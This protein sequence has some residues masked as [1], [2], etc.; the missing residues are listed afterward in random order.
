MNRSTEEE[1]NGISQLQSHKSKKIKALCFVQL[2]KLDK[3]K[4][5]YFFW[6]KALEQSYGHIL[7]S[8]PPCRW[9]A[10]LK[11]KKKAY[12][13]SLAI[14]QKKK[15]TLPSQTLNVEE[16]KVSL[17]FLF[18]A[19]ELRYAIFF[20]LQVHFAWFFVICMYYTINDNKKNE[21]N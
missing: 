12:L 17:F 9:I 16:I 13:S 4:C 10:R 8:I 19:R 5:L 7:I 3:A 1:K 18:M 11:M 15:C 2:L 14:N 20:S 6:F 21:R